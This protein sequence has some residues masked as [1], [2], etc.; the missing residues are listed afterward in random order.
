MSSPES[1]TLKH[2]RFTR[3]MLSHAVIEENIT[4]EIE[5]P[6]GSDDSDDP[7]EPCNYDFS[8]P[9]GF[10]RLVEFMTRG[11]ERALF[12]TFQI[13]GVQNILYMQAEIDYLE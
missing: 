8:L 3:A 6:D 9:A 5:K 13:L 7:E 4:T 2:L 11:P 1:P 12:R 10:P